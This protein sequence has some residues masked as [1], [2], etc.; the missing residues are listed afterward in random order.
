MTST[1]AKI[2]PSAHCHSGT[3]VERFSASS[4]PVTTAERS[5]TDCSRRAMRL[6]RNSEITAAAMQ[7][8]IIVS[9]FVPK[10]TTAAIE[11]GSSAMITSS[12]IR[13]ELSVLWI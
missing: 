11:A 8:Q 12:M 9:A 4:N 10:S 2:E 1:I 7:T 6:N 13:R 5:P 3:L